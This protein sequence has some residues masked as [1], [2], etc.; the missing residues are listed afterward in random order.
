MF[1]TTPPQHAP[2]LPA[3]PTEPQVAQYAATVQAR[4]RTI[5]QAAIATHA[6]Y[7]LKESV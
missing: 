2:F 7:K 5:Q 3:T 1:G 6:S 4:V